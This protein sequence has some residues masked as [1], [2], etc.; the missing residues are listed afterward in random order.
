MVNYALK[1]DN[2]TIRLSSKAKKKNIQIQ[3]EILPIIGGLRLYSNQKGGKNPNKILTLSPIL[4]INAL[5]VDL[6]K[7]FEI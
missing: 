5:E 3:E 4:I 7:K 6:R 2:Q 1:H